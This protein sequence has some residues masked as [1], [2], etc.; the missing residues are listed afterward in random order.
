[1]LHLLN[2]KLTGKKSL[3]HRSMPASR[4][5]ISPPVVPSWL[6]AAAGNDLKIESGE[7]RYASEYYRK[8]SSSG[9]LSSSSKERRD[10]VEST[11]ALASTFSGEKVDLSAGRDLSVTAAT[12][13]RKETHYSKTKQS[14]LFSSG[15]VGFTIGSRMNSTDQK[16]ESTSAAKS[17][18]GSLE[19]TVNLLAGGTYKQVGSDIIALKG[20]SIFSI[21]RS[22]TYDSPFSPL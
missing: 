7:A 4:K 5:V 15:G 3:S 9:L 16:S 19:G 11:T 10:T 17:T 2:A 18:V 22:S 20:H 8:S 13:T 14:G 12:E 1:M 21:N 6:A